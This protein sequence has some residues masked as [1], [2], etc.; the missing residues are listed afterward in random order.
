[1]RSP[2]EPS[3]AEPRLY[4]PA[5]ELI[6]ET[7]SI[8]TVME[9]SDASSGGGAVGTEKVLNDKKPVKCE[10]DSYMKASVLPY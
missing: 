3:P 5:A 9:E 10:S 7:G 4:Q 8:I 2:S 6:S 1:M